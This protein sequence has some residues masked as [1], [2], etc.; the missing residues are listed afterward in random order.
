MTHRPCAVDTSA[1]TVRPEVIDTLANVTDGSA[2]VGQDLIIRFI[3]YIYIII[4]NERGQLISFFLI[5][6]LLYFNIYLLKETL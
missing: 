1:M 3:S 4:Q 5:F 2:I 6:Y